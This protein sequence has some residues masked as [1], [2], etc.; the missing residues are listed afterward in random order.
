MDQTALPPLRL[1]IHY[2]LLTSQV[3]RSLSSVQ[4]GIRAFS[5]PAF[6]AHIRRMPQRDQHLHCDD[7]NR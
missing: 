2:Q 3:L 1:R 4:L 6:P 7:H 5:P